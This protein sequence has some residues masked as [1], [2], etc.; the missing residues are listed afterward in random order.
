MIRQRLLETSNDLSFRR[1]KTYTLK[2]LCLTLPLVLGL[3]LPAVAESPAEKGL[4][5]AKEADRRDQGW[6]DTVAELTM[7]L[8]NKQGNESHR[9]IR[10]RGLE[11]PEDGDRSLVIFDSPR[12][13]KGTALLTFSHKVGTD[14]QWLYLPA[15]KRVKR[16]ASRNKSGPFVGSEF[17]YEDMTPQE[18]EK[19]TYKYIHDETFDGWNCFVV[20]RFPVDK[21]SGY[22]KQVIW[23][24]KRE[25]RVLR[26]EYFDRK[27]SHLKTLMNTE[28]KQFLDKHWRPH[29]SFMQNHQS[30]KSTLLTY[31][32]YK[33]KTGLSDSDF[34]KNRLKS[35]R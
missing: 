27:D 19:F 12:D 23:V 32:N 35:V 29:K 21:Y 13:V 16:I 10:I 6:K 30:G 20:E 11:I 24:D 1:R 34:N 17:S 15:V 26:I 2:L 9:E 33:F 7:L 4:A 3:M 14:D 8:R 28:W 22:T 18:V 25:Y 31:R 5:I